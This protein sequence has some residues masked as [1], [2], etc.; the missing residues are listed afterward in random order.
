MKTLFKS[1][2]VWKL[3]EEGF[4]YLAGSNEEADKLKEIK[5]KDAKAL[6]L[7]QQAVHDTIFSRIA[8]AT[9]SSQAWKILKKKFQGSTKVITVKLQTYRRD[10]ETLS[11]KSNEFVQAYL[12]KVSY[13]VNQMK[14]YGEDISEVIVV[15]K[16]LR[17]LTP[18]FKHIVVAIEE[19]HDLVDYTFD[20]LMCSLQAHEERL[21][22][23]CSN[24]MSGTKS[25]FKDLD[26]SKKSDVRLGDNKKIQVEGEGTVSIMT[27]QGN[28][29]ILEDVM[30]VPSLSHNLLSIGQLMIS[31]YSISFDD[32]VCTIK[33]KKSGKTIAKVPMIN[34]KMFPLE[35]SM[36]EKCVMVA[37]G[38]DE[39]RLWHLRYGHLNVNE[40]KL[41]S[42]KKVVFGL[43]KVENLDFCE[44]CVY[45]KQSKNVFPVGKSWRASVCLEDLTA[46]FTPEQNGVAERKNRTVVE[47]GRSMIQG[48]ECS[49][50][51]LLPSD[52]VVD[53]EY[54]ADQ[55]LADPIFFEDAETED[56]WCK[57]MEEE[58]LAIQKN[59]TWDLVFRTEYHADGS[60][61]KQKARLVAKCYSQKQG[62][63]FDETSSPVARFE[64]VI[65]FLA[66]T[67]NLYWPVYQFDVKY[68]FLNGDLEEEVYVSRP[69]G[70]VVNGKEDKV[71][72]LNKALYGLKQA[73]R[74]WYFK[75]DWYF[76]EN[77]F[78]R[79]NNEPTLYVKQEGKNDFLV[80]FMHNP[81][82][83]HLGAAKR[84]LRYIAGTTEHGIWYS[85]VTNFTL[86]G[87]TDSDYAGNI[88]DR[89]STSGFLFNLGS[90]AISWSS[91]KQE[92]VALSTS[93]AEYI[94]ATSA[95]CQAV[96]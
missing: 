79:S 1:Q 62:I 51:Q 25:L 96:W 32:G 39:T 47:M 88:D 11:M 36:V 17:S 75:I 53:Q 22:S 55:F 87:F 28:A 2:G 10:F 7:I 92:V 14:S 78:E 86:T 35:V 31:G 15:A 61:V 41:L 23:G 40:L 65:T 57:A 93:K 5:K 63:D 72:R 81:S 45:G 60:I 46:P 85:K 13:L 9:T 82:K 50:I 37:S 43:P 64:T 76:Q 84:V 89:K 29:K 83:L 33:N 95:A 4:V 68:V 44:S 21:L 38:D 54:G 77:G 94:A 48:N 27:S 6:S 19:S 71:Y 18:K 49:N 26:E 69:E 58:L 52:V 34:N 12:S 8:A 90:G 42:Q 67:A 30:F 16:I 59:Q 66:L 56:K 20:E 70:F 73:P 3:V 74:A 24:H 80:R 91:K